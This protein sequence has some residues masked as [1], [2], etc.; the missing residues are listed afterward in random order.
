MAAIR[1]RYGKFIVSVLIAK[2]IVVFFLTIIELACLI[3]VFSLSKSSFL[4]NMQQLWVFFSNFLLAGIGKE[5]LGAIRTFQ[6]KQTIPI[7]RGY[8]VCRPLAGGMD[9]LE[10]PWV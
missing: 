5:L 7:R 1:K 4:L 3:I 8:P 9:S 10:R 6:T 2:G